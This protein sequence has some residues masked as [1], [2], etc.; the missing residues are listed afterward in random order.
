MPVLVAERLWVRTYVYI[1]FAVW[2]NSPVDGDDDEVN[3]TVI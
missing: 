1:L 2:V 3:D